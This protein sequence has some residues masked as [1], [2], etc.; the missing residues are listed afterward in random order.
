[1]NIKPRLIWADSVYPLSFGL[2]TAEIFL[3]AS[4]PWRNCSKDNSTSTSKANHLVTRKISPSTGTI[5]ILTTF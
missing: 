3:F 4:L 1:M 5:P 2:A